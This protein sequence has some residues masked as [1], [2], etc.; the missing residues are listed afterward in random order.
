MKTLLISIIA[1][2][3]SNYI[4]QEFFSDQKRSTYSPNLTVNNYFPLEESY[5]LNPPIQKNFSLPTID[6]NNI[7]KPQS[8]TSFLNLSLL[9][10]EQNPIDNKPLLGL[11]MD[12]NSPPNDSSNFFVPNDENLNSTQQVNFSNCENCAAP[13]MHYPSDFINECHSCHHFNYF[14]G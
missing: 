9:N 7:E 4:F 1:G 14:S 13:I 3:I 8:E 12:S 10:E 5:N 11:N 6:L 2:V